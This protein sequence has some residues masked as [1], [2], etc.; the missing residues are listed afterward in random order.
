MISGA[1]IQKLLPYPPWSGL[2]GFGSVSAAV[3]WQGLDA[4]LIVELFTV[5]FSRQNPGACQAPVP[6]CCHRE[7]P[8]ASVR[9]SNLSSLAPDWPSWLWSDARR[10]IND[11]PWASRTRF[12]QDRPR[13]LQL[14]ACPARPHSACYLA[15]GIESGDYSAGKA[16]LLPKASL[17]LDDPL[18]RKSSSTGHWRDGW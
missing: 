11:A 2:S 4:P 15:H 10:G 8:D 1:R 18:S 5:C 9:S 17:E 12:G 13:T 7:A 6:R 16:G 14:S 3:H